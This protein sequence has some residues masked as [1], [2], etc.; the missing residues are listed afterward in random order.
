MMMFKGLVKMKKCFIALILLVSA[1]SLTACG[2]SKATI[3]E[4]QDKYQELLATHNQVAESYATIEEGSLNNELQA[5][6]DKVSELTEYNLYE[7]T[8]DE[9]DALIDTMNSMITSYSDY[10]KTIGEIKIVEEKTLLTPY[11]FSVTNDTHLVFSGLSLSE[12]GESDLVSDAL[13]GT[14]GLN[15]GQTLAGLTVYRDAENTPHVMTLSVN[16]EEG[17][18]INSYKLVIDNEVLPESGAK[19][20]LK[21][22]EETAEVYLE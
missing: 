7:M 18:E 3:A 8:D 14:A 9:I 15:P 11:V 6:S 16:D 20:H 1:I 13:L 5:M 17:I 21:W 19:L 12:R 10:L 2:P 4:A 22:N